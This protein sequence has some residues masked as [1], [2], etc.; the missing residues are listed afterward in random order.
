MELKGGLK[1]P[2]DPIKRNYN[3]LFIEKAAFLTI[4][5]NDDALIRSFGLKYSSQS[6]ITHRPS[7]TLA[8]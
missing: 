4:E 7:A 5:G 2:N 8:I 6:E 3:A 1:L